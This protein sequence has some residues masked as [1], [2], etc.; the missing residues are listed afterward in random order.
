M[1][2]TL[3]LWFTLT[4]A[5]SA[6]PADTELPY[7]AWQTERYPAPSGVVLE[8]PPAPPREEPEQARRLWELVPELGLALPSCRKRAESCGG[9]RPGLDVGITGLYRPMPYFAFGVSAHFDAFSLGRSRSADVLEASTSFFG[10][11][12]R[13]YAFESG[14]FDP[15]LELALGG[16]SLE[17]SGVDARGRVGT[18]VDFAPAARVAAGLD[19]ALGSWLRLGPVF[20][21]SEYAPRTASVCGAGGCVSRS[22]ERAALPRGSTSFGF[23]LSLSAGERL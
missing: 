3:P 23:R 22:A 18:H 17:T 5:A 14:A 2:L 19:F 21:V 8:R 1:S 20:A 11:A 7:A 10:V 12:G 4:A 6:T 13:V 15:Y 9:I 16:G